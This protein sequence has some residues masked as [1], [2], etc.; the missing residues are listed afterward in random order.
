[1]NFS[2]MEQQF[3]KKILLQIHNLKLD[4]IELESRKHFFSK[5]ERK[6]K[7]FINFC[8]HGKIRVDI[9]G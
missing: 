9:R 6:R 2:S 7:D 8:M 5:N 3:L 4:L 1:M